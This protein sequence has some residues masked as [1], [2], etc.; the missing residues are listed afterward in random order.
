ML[1]LSLYSRTFR[2]AIVEGTDF[3]IAAIGNLISGPLFNNAGYAGVFVL[4]GVGLNGM[5]FY[6]RQIKSLIIGQEIS[7]V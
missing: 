1:I 4:V 3:G 2:L 7:N 5:V 6:N